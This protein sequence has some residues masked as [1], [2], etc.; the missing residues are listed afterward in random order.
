MLTGIGDQQILALQFA[1]AALLR[2]T[3]L[4]RQ[5]IR[6][7][8]HFP[9]Y[10][11]HHERRR[12]RVLTQLIDR[13]HAV[14]HEIRTRRREL[15]EHES[16]TVAEDDGVG[17]VDRLE[18]LRFARRRRHADLLLADERVDGARLADVRVADEADDEFGRCGAGRVREG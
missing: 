2:P 16:G 3:D 4:H 12:A 5:A 7:L 10:P 1:I 17:E 9:W 6:C 15:R 13:Q 11:L 18:V 8:E 14:A